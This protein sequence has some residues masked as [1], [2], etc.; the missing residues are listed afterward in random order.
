MR[1]RN[2]T[3]SNSR[4]TEGQCYPFLI[5]KVMELGSD[6][7]FVMQDPLG[8]KVLMPR[9]FYL[10]YG[11][12]PGQTIQCRVDRIN[13]NGRM[14]I[15]PSHPHYKEG[16]SYLFPVIESGS[17][18][19]MLGETEH[20]MWV[21][22]VFEQKWKVRV[23]S[24]QLLQAPG[25]QAF[26]LLERIKKGKLFLS[27]ASGQP[28][29]TDLETGRSYRFRIVAETIHPEDKSALFVLED[30]KGKKHPLRK[31][32]FIHYGLK[33]GDWIECVADKFTSE[34]YFFLEP[35]NPWYKV[36][37]EYVFRVLELH[38]L[39]F[40]DGSVQD[41]LVLQDPYGEDIKLFVDTQQLQK[42]EGADRIRCRVL[43]IRKSRLE[44][45]IT[46]K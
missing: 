18:V 25:S 23:G 6:S 34:G 2:L 32:Y 19:G 27:F 1:V 39:N 4:L 11:F 12:E 24:E 33:I 40:S 9:N 30:S 28:I 10:N 22:D 3:V 36:G 42:I 13:C 38:K 37:S 45:E 35:E 8:Y 21:K 5:L 46:G 16:K 20:F 29:H 17:E 44:L 26:C 15:E 43:R 14:F 7:Y 41:V 31:R